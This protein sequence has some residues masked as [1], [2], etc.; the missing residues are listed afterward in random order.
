MTFVAI[1][2]N[3]KKSLTERKKGRWGHHCLFYRGRASRHFC[4]CVQSV[5]T[6]VLEGRRGPGGEK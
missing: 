4:V 5:V 2:A 3:N 6:R 1:H